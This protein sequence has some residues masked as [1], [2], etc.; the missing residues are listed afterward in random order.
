MKDSFRLGKGN[1]VTVIVDSKKHWLARALHPQT[2]S[3]LGYIRFLKDKGMVELTNFNAQL[4]RRT[5]NMGGGDKQFKEY[6]A[7]G[8]GEGY[9]AAAVVALRKGYQFRYEASSCYWNFHCGKLDK[10]PEQIYCHLQPKRPQPLQ[11]TMKDYDDRFGTGLPRNE[12]SYIHQDVSVKIGNVSKYKK[13]SGDKISERV[14]RKLIRVSLDLISPTTIAT[15]YGELIVD[16]E[17]QDTTYLKRLLVEGNPGMANYKY[18]YHFFEG[19]IDRDRRRLPNNREDASRG[20][21]IWEY[22][23]EKQPEYLGKYIE[24]IEDVDSPWADV[25]WAREFVS[26]HFAE[27]MCKYYFDGDD[28]KQIFYHDS[29]TSDKAWTLLEPQPL[30]N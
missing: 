14:F 26:R 3:L 20:A 15:P 7:G 22:V 25:C 1:F 6:L 29:R 24:M 23:V 27:K 4:A 16:S 13:K 18:G 17:F 21:K 19:K 28:K 30:L 2:R 8:H 12:T 5:L 9:K 11:K 10:S